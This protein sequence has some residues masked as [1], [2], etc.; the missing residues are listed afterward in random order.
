MITKITSVNGDEYNVFFNDIND[1]FKAQAGE[2]AT[3]VIQ[4]HSL[5]EY[6]AFIEQVV[7]LGKVK[8]FALPLDEEPLDIDANTRVIKLPEGFRRN[9]IAVQGEHL[10]E[11]LFFRI[12][13]YFD[14]QDLGSDDLSIYIQW[15]LPGTEG[16]RGISIPWVKDIESQPGKLIFGWALPEKLT[17]IAGNLKFSVRF[18]KLEGGV[19]TYNFNTLPQTAKINAS[20]NYDLTNMDALEV[21]E[22]DVD[23]ILNRLTN[24]SIG[25][26][27]VGK[28]VFYVE[29]PEE[30]AA[31]I[32]LT[33]EH[34]TTV[35]TVSAYPADKEFTSI[36]YTWFK[37]SD[38]V[39][40]GSDTEFVNTIDTVIDDNKRYFV[41]APDAEEYE[42]V[43]TAE[44]AE[45]LAT[46]RTLV[47]EEVSTLTV[48][49]SGNYQ[50]K[51]IA[52]K[53]FPSVGG[54]TQPGAS[55]P[56]SFSKSWNFEEPSE[57]VIKSVGPDST[58]QPAA[59]EGKM[60]YTG[61]IISEGTKPDITITYPVAASGQQR[62]ATYSHK[63]YRGINESMADKVEVT[64][65]EDP[66]K[67]IDINTEGYYQ[68][69]VTKRLNLVNET[70]TSPVVWITHKATPPVLT[71]LTSTM[72]VGS[73]PIKVKVSGLNPKYTYFYTWKRK[74]SASDAEADYGNRDQLLSVTNS[75]EEKE[76]SITP[77]GSGIYWVAVSARYNGD[78]ATSISPEVS[79]YSP[80]A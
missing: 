22:T 43:T 47:Y 35:L 8:Y 15:E 58:S 60:V 50:V 23:T 61:K 13:R 19:I 5:A 69:E 45:A 37:D 55:S 53:T 64:A 54:I 73:D 49:S 38:I 6:Y 7:G 76:L 16:L 46:D 29:L 62:F 48:E 1:A 51:A 9:G 2:G 67:Y 31:D 80:L 78:D 40:Q 17:S 3:E 12:D 70:S 59:E 71:L 68:V 4:I 21:D 44:A 39:K 10:A 74:A 63:L 57:F 42:L 52:K 66:L 56:E 72:S 77:L 26:V 27:E 28:P 36:E 65:S 25:G 32:I 20:F 79:V 34:P 24:S 75:N 18:F 11:N 41:K 14:I 30:I 33:D